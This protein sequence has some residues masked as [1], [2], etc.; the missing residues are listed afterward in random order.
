[1]EVSSEEVL[2]SLN[3]RFIVTERHVHYLPFLSL[4]NRNSMMMIMIGNYSIYLL[5]ELLM[6]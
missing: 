3:P 1:M 6:N 5:L 4:G 2:V